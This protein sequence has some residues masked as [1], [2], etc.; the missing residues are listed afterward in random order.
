MVDMISPSSEAPALERPSGSCLSSP[1]PDR[2]GTGQG[3]AP[4][5]CHP[6]ER[7]AVHATGYADPERGLALAVIATAVRDLETKDAKR[8]GL[9]RKAYRWLTRDSWTLRLWCEL[10]EVPLSALRERAKEIAN[11]TGA[12]VRED[13][14]L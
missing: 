9:R 5:P 1:P 4:T 2:A 13:E 14:A 8:A 11:L 12:L 6:D 3:R 7:L 10:G